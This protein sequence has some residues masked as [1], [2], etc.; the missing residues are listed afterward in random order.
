[1][2]LEKEFRQMKALAGNQVIDITI[3][4][5]RALGY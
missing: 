3:F 4:L 5:A 2:T 1:M